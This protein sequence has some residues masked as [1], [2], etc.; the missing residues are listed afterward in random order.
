MLMA[1]APHFPILKNPELEAQNGRAI[2]LL[3]LL[4]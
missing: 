1:I 3:F 2:A 4:K